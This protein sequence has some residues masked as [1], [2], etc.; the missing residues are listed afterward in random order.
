[1]A[2]K[3]IDTD[4]NE[5]LEKINIVNGKGE[6]SKIVKIDGRS[7]ELK[8]LIRPSR[9]RVKKVIDDSMFDF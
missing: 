1:M 8:I 4:L 6:C 5:L 2:S 9:K 7:Y 3:K